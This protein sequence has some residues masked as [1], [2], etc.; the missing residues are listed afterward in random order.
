MTSSASGTISMIV[1]RK[2]WSVL[3]F[4]SL[5]PRRYSSTSS[6]D[7]ARSLGRAGLGRV[8]SWRTCK[9]VVPA[10]TC[11]AI[12]HRST[13]VS[14]AGAEAQPSPPPVRAAAPHHLAATGRHARSRP[15]RNARGARRSD[16]RDRRRPAGEA[17]RDLVSGL[18]P[19]RR[20]AHD[21]PPPDPSTPRSTSSRARSE[22]RPIP[23]RA[24]R[25]HAST[26]RGLRRNARASCCRR[27]RASR[28]PT[29]RK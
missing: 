17:R 8:R 3:R 16:L 13:C 27:T 10:G 26:H 23:A 12:A 5:R 7:T 28:Q 22:S 1:R 19:G 2:L 6:A 21:H 29:S 24:L 14:D 20:R 9:R 18:E 4:G 15:R 25:A 11:S